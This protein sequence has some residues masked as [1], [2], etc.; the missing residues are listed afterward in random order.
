M[1]KHI[2]LAYYRKE[3]WDRL[4]AS[5]DDPESMDDTWEEW[6]QNFLKGKTGLIL[7]GFEVKD[8]P[9]D[10]DKLIQYCRKRGIKNDG[11]ARSQFV[12]EP[13]HR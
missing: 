8:I 7:E 10:I 6:H 13:E 12:V 5:I 9:V 11:N 1:R 3:D 2:H 4:I